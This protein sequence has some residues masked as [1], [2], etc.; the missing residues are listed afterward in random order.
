MIRRPAPLPRPRPSDWEASYQWPVAAW[1]RTS[2]AA[3]GR[4][5]LPWLHLVGYVVAALAL[6]GFLVVGVVRGVLR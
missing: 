1:E 5:P 6:V 2:R 3:R 4:L